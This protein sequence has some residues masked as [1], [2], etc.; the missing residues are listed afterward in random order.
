MFY[1]HSFAHKSSLKRIHN[2]MFNE[3]G[4]SRFMY[5]AFCDVCVNIEKIYIKFWFLFGDFHQDPHRPFGDFENPVGQH[6]V[7]SGLRSGLRSAL[8]ASLENGVK[9]LDN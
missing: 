8:R 5:K 4:R 1:F 2:Q 3:K 6:A 7:P 9:T